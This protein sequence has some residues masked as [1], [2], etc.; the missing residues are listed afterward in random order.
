MS[1]KV[2]LSGMR[3]PKVYSALFKL[4]RDIIMGVYPVGSY[5]KP[6][7]KI[8]KDTGIGICSA[9]AIHKFLQDEGFC[10]Y[11]QRKGSVVLPFDAEA[12]QKKLHTE[13]LQSLIETIEECRAA[14]IPEER[15]IKVLR[16]ACDWMK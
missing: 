14:N 3:S 13:L 16:S 6:V 2:F 8:S 12:W 15:I 4:R 11:V 10:E 1:D 9:Y 7:V 5:I